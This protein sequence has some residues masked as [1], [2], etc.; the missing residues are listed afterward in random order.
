MF[1]N[2][3]LIKKDLDQDSLKKEVKIFK[4]E[5]KMVKLKSN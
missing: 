1:K 2:K 5:I 4:N 3:K